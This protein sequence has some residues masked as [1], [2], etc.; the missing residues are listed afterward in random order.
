MTVKNESGRYEVH[1]LGGITDFV[2][3]E[4]QKLYISR[5]SFGGGGFI[6]LGRE[7]ESFSSKDSTKIILCVQSISSSKRK[8]YRL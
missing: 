2:S 1:F 4:E 8:A 7:E 6:S 3:L 5:G